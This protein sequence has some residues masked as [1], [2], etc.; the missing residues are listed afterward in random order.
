VQTS[1][2]LG[3]ADLRA[4]FVTYREILHAHRQVINR[5]NVFPVP[6]G[7]TGTNLS[8]TV[9]AV[10]AEL[11]SDAG[12][13]A[14]ARAIGHGAVMGARG[15]S[16]VIAAQ[17]FRSA[18]DHLAVAPEVDGASLAAALDAAARAAYGAVSRPVEGT[19]LTV[20]R[21]A[22][23]AAG[24]A[25]GEG[26]L[27]TVIQAARRAAWEAV[28]RTPDL[29]PVLRDAGVVDG[30][31]TG[32]ALFFDAL[33][34][35]VA[36]TPL[37]DPSDR[38]ADPVLTAWSR[39]SSA[40][41]GAGDGA[42]SAHPSD[43]RPPGGDHGDRR[44]EVA[45]LLEA[46]DEAV[47]AFRDVWNRLGGAVVVVGG[48]GRWS[49]HVHTDHPGSAVDAAKSFG[50]PSDVRVTDLALQ[51]VEERGDLAA[52]QERTRCG[53]VA[54]GAGD[55]IH[56]LFRSLGARVVTGIGS[57]NPSVR[58]LVEAVESV[59]SDEVVVLPNDDD[60]APA[61]EQ[62]AR[63]SG[64]RVVVVPTRGIAHG[65]AALRAFDPDAPAEENAEAMSEAARSVSF[66]R[67]VRAVRD[68]GSEVGDIHEGDWLG[69]TAEG[70]R[71]VEPEVRQAGRALLERLLSDRSEIVTIIEG[72]GATEE[73]TRDLTDW[74]QAIRPEIGV[75]VL[76]GGQPIH[77]YLFGLE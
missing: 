59:A 7:D 13:E 42:V 23:A 40:P 15:I 35:V 72:E 62:V 14:T 37:P 45:L 20:A 12:M 31:G 25:A 17:L 60:V 1:G 55:G 28:E 43:A 68:A 66:G 38:A 71:V 77:A 16:G 75:Q 52:P 4:A 67:L 19:I 50:R 10:V 47:P 6:D 22:A 8:L 46:P 56:R 18:V 69:I 54:V 63:L 49:A 53:A 24:S 36:G 5:L 58:E 57:P 2:R 26:D 61:A 32:F 30:G 64:K 70:I 76:H 73:V 29:L 44:F 33:L 39:W 3:P 65:L 48:G 34:H 41:D 21:E 74:L 51:I 11:E 9:D 27:L